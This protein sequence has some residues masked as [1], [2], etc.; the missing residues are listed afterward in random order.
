MK[1]GIAVVDLY[2]DAEW[3][4]IN[5]QKIRDRAAENPE[6]LGPEAAI[7]EAIYYFWAHNI[8]AETLESYISDLSISAQL[9]DMLRRFFPCYV[10]DQ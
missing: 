1:Y 8:T 6:N 4:K 2:A 10:R 5:I 9:A 3:R 7:C